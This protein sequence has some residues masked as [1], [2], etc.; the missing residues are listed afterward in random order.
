MKTR[1]LAAAVLVPAL[2]LVM[3]VL[4]KEL[5]AVIIGSPL[6]WTRLFSRARSLRPVPPAPWTPREE[7]A[8]ATRVG[9]TPSVF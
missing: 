5:A 1:I 6:G 3:L 2:F 7:A 9:A 4:P 8:G